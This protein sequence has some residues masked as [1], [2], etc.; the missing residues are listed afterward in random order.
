MTIEDLLIELEGIRSHAY[1]DPAGLLTIG[2]GHLLTRSEL[3]SGKIRGVWVD[4]QPVK[5]RDGLT[6]DQCRTLCAIDLENSWNRVL[7]PWVSLTDAQRIALQ[8]FTFNVG[9]E[10]FM[11]STLRKCLL[12]AQYYYVPAQMRRWVYAGGKKVPGLAKR[13]E[14]EIAVW[15]GTK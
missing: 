11:G 3:T 13:R 6:E 15:E 5:Y 9:R 1:R 14:R 4:G 8:S 7:P 2:I 12:D 10:A